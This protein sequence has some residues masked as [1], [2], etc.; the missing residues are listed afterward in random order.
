MTLSPIDHTLKHNSYYQ[1]VSF[2]QK[3]LLKFFKAEGQAENILGTKPTKLA[4][5]G[6]ASWRAL[7]PRGERASNRQLHFEEFLNCLRGLPV[8]KSKLE[9]FQAITAEPLEDL[10]FWL[11]EQAS[12]IEPD[13]EKTIDQIKNTAGLIEQVLLFLEQEPERLVQANVQKEHQEKAHH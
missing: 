5:S 11:S 12:P 7:K 3:I 6:L 10:R 1:K 4:L 8:V 2:T 13:I 9:D